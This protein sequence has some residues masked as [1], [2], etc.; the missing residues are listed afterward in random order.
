MDIALDDD[1]LRLFSLSEYSIN[2]LLMTTQGGIFCAIY[3]GCYHLHLD[4]NNNGME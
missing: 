1:D 4:N 3:M 2:M